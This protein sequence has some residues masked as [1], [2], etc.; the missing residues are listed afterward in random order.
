M[1]HHAER[2][3][4]ATGHIGLI[5]L[6]CKSSILSW[7]KKSLAAV[8]RTAFTNYIMQ[9]MICTLLFYGY[10]FGLFGRMDITS[11]LVVVG[12][13]WFLQMVISPFWLKYFQF[14]PL[15]W[16]WRSLTYWKIQPML[17][18]KESS[19]VS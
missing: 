14:G 12:A 19:R 10:G 15:E 17:I 7:L 8:G 16:A 4:V 13:V 5:C 18:R 6:F 2:V 11:Q 1:L 3:A 9:S